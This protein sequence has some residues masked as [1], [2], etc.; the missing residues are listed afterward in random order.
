MSDE[1]SRAK[2][3]L[4]RALDQLEQAEQELGGPVERADLIVVYS[5]GRDEEDGWH[6]VG[7]Y[8][9]TPGP[10]YTHAALLRVAADE[11]KSHPAE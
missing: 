4:L 3:V 9:T 8:A 5:L 2:A 7:G 6:Q 1:L 10:D 11:Q